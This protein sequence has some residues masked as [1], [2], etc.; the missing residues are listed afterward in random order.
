MMPRP[1]TWRVRVQRSTETYVD[2]MAYSPASAE[3]EALKVP[4]VV[5]VYAKSAM[6]IDEAQKVQT[7]EDG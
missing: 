5:S 3:S 1:S 7:G 2:V 4:G 6:R